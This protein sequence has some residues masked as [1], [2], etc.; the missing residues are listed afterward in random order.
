MIA[1]L[2]P[3]ALWGLGLLA[4]PVAVHLLQRRQA[5]RVPFPSTRFVRPSHTAA[6][7]LRPPSDLILL[8]LRM[9]IVAVAALAAAQPLLLS[10][11]RVAGWNGRTARAIVLDAS[12]SMRMPRAGGR[13]ALDEGEAA[14]AAEAS[15][16]FTF[17]VAHADLREGLVRA[18]AWLKTAPPARREIVVISDFQHGSLTA[19]PVESIQQGIGIR[20]VRTSGAGTPARAEGVP[21]LRAP[22]VRRGT[23]R[24][25]LTPEG[26][27]LRVESD[28]NR[29]APVQAS[30]SSTGLRILGR[31]HAREEPRLLAILAQ[32]GVPAADPEEPIA[33]VFTP[34]PAPADASRRFARW[35][36]STLAGIERDPELASLARELDAAALAPSDSW[37]VLLRD[38]RA[39]PLVRAAA[40]DR[41]LLLQIAAPASGYFAAAVTRAALVTRYGRLDRPEQE[42]LAIPPGTLSAW[43]RRP[44]PVG[45]SAWRNADVSDAR[46]FWAGALVLYVAEHLLRWRTS[47]RK[48]ETRAAA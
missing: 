26:T 37:T 17:R 41:E 5:D 10:S 9:A 13:T 12:E 14:A 20:F 18:E 27:R 43:S 48:E 21:L 32:A 40:S 46:W 35:M 38:R 34:A 45:E 36:L 47:A 3:W 23:Q 44:G 25:E 24:I 31:E 19:G 6:V 7:R 33:V 15:A 22:G 30:T 11:S 28:G 16:E 29:A 39:K 2:Q 1:W 8:L 42:P 4:L